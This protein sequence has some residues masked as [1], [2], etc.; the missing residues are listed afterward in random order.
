M[1]TEL[2]LLI[3]FAVACSP[4]GCDRVRERLSDSDH[5]AQERHEQA[6]QTKQAEPPL[7][8]SPPP[9][10]A[11]PATPQG[12]L[13]VP[14]LIER[15]GPSV[16]N[17]T[18]NATVTLP[19]FARPLPPGLQRRGPTGGAPTIQRRALGTGFI[20]DAR[21][22]VV[23]N[24]HVVEGAD[25]IEVKLA[26]DRV[27]SARV[28]GRDRRLDL[29]LLEIQKGG[30]L[31]A[32]SLG[33][34]DALRVGEPVLAIGN[35]F[36]LGH[37]VTLGIVSA[38]SRAIGAG[39]YDD[40]IQTDASIN[41]GNSGGPLFN[42]RGEVIGINTAIN[43]SGQGI[44]FAIP[45]DDLR[46][47]LPQLLDKGYVARGSLGVAIQPIDP[48]MAEA[49]GLRDTRGALVGDL[50]R[51][52]PAERAGLREGDVIHS[53]AGAT[54]ERAQ[55][56]PRLVAKHAPGEKIE[57][58]VA[59]GGTARS[60]T[61]ELGQ[62]DDPGLAPTGDNQPRTGSSTLGL[63]L[64]DADDRGARIERVGQGSVAA[65]KLVPGDVI[66]EVSGQVVKNAEQAT[67]AIRDAPR[68]KPLLLKVE[69]RD[70]TL[71]VALEPASS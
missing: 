22:H 1:R 70:R 62:L 29:A 16:V 2:S 65:G 7:P 44:G 40:F 21:G 20:I 26:D 68:D 24:A 23:T 15:L 9:F 43:A 67:R 56:L 60:L 30:D 54:V 69:R 14:A 35:P 49:L 12:I 10:A 55:D 47:V 59:R 36:G 13:D 18:A 58:G 66:L 39:P 28:R 71:F 38:K 33:S 41:P 8:A 25:E 45:S 37:T 52:G 46:Q 48:Q 5:G 27:L 4:A 31:P 42:S 57:V 11:P 17:I 19:G 50:E 51:G 6:E 63:E 3:A 61:V 34:S 64:A 53:V 32:V